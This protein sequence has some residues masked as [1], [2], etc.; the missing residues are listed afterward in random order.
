MRKVKTDKHKQ[1]VHQITESRNKFVAEIM[2]NNKLTSVQV[3]M[4][5]KPEEHAYFYEQ[6]S[7]LYETITERVSTGS[8][9]S[10]RVMKGVRMGGY[11]GTSRTQSRRSLIDQGE[12]VITNLSIIFHGTKQN[13]SLPLK[14]VFSVQAGQDHIEI[15]IEGKSTAV[16]FTVSNPRICE[17]LLQILKKEI[18]PNNLSGINWIADV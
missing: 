18:D 10:F 3:P 7:K 2:T 15:A 5:L 12:L 9:G 6:N 17:V 1:S 16:A 8:F 11:T 4:L 14:K 13:R